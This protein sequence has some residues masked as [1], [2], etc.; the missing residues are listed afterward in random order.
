MKK[1]GLILA[2]AF[3]L[4]FA[5]CSE[6]NYNIPGEDDFVNVSFS[7]MLDQSAMTRGVTGES[8]GTKATKLY[9]AVYNAS[10]N[11]ISGISKIDN[12]TVTMDEK[13]ASVSFQLVKGQTY[14]FAF[15]AQNPE[16]T[17]GALTFDAAA[18]TVT[19]DYT[20]IKANDESLDAFTA[21]VNNLTVTGPVTQNVTLK[22][23]WAQLN[24][25][26]TSADW[27]AAE[28][29]GII[30]TQSKVTVSN[31][32][33]TLNLLDGTVSD[34]T[35]TDIVLDA[36]N[37]P[38]HTLT[39]SSTDYKQLGLNYLL[40]GNEGEQGLIKADLTVLNAAGE[41]NTLAF[42]NI[43]VQR[44][45]RTNII[46]D[47]LT[48]AVNFSVTIDPAYDDDNKVSVSTTVD[49]AGNKFIESKDDAG[50][51]VA[52]T[53][54]VKTNEG[55][56]TALQN[57]EAKNIT[58]VLQDDGTQINFGARNTWGGDNTE[59]IVIDGNGKTV[60]LGGTD[61]DWSSIGSKNGT[62]TIKNATVNFQRVNG[63]NNA[64][65]NHALNFSGKVIAENVTFTNSVSVGGDSEFKNCTFTE[66]GAF[67]TLIVKANVNNVS[68]DNCTFTATSGGRGIKVMD[69]YIDEAE[70]VQVKISVSNSTFT[71]AKKAAILVTNTAGAIITA[72]GTNNISA[73][74]EDSENLVWND[75]DRAAVYDLVEVSGCTKKQE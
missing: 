55:L 69:Q 64:W 12:N 38:T 40:V 56:T 75:E 26:T 57:T 1:L 31:V 16:A 3:P 35:S 18:K 36:A 4:L 13:A 65:N 22:R 28:D 39:V 70:R 23:P 24:Y 34:N 47:L 48:S 67:Y 7:T 66:A 27:D 63:G 17:T 42:S 19:V 58:V 71:T 29:A 43:P 44:N 8:D 11:L 73:V 6:D 15:W 30:V 72:S 51:L 20:K 60:T 10:G 5:A 59:N 21:H 33:S 68:V 50:V 46:G 53:A 52:L 41:I 14:N 61:S 74:T 32:Y 49:A 37:I 45:Y 9:V 25:G 2:A 54:E 62:V